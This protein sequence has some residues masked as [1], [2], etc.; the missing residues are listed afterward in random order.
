M[1]QFVRTWWRAPRRAP[2]THVGENGQ[3]L[4]L[5][6]IGLVAFCGLVGLSIDVGH[7]VYMRTDLQK[8]VDAAALAGAQDLPT[9][10]DA[11][12][13]ALEYV[14][15]NAP[16]GTTAAVQFSQSDTAIR[17]TASRDVGFTFLKVLGIDSRTVS[18]TAL[19]TVGTYSGGSGLLPW[20]FIASNDDNS[21]LLQ[22]SCY[23]GQVN[24]VP[25]FQSGVDCVVKYGAG[26]NSG[27]DFGS[28]GLDGPGGNRYRDAI[29][30]GSDSF[31]EV[32]DTVEPETGNM[33]G[34]TGQ[35]IE[36]RL[37]RPTPPGCAGDDRDDILNDH[38]GGVVSIVDG[39][40]EHPRIGI[41]PVV[42]Q[43]DNPHDS[44]ILGFAFIFIKEYDVQSG[45][46]GHAEVTVEFVEFVTELPN[47]V[48]E[49]T[50][51]GSTAITLAE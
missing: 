37:D 21:T 47:S 42:D 11:N 51:D 46:N 45:G 29:E 36:R 8:T 22:N 12:A 20:G 38:G 40:E 31:F 50:G 32:G 34:P 19:V 13:T 10:S 18:A 33:V 24:G 7:M 28:L 39:C 9:T 4:A 16:G 27:G 6:A 25:E 14:G 23:V 17:V 1:Q 5:F 44:T 15:Y 41:I 49:G 43:I 2:S 35:G 26:T 48:Y 30:N 3:A